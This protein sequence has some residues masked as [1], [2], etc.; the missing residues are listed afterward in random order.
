MKE[1]AK[2]TRTKRKAKASDECELKNTVSTPTMERFAK[3]RNVRN[4]TNFIFGSVREMKMY[5]LIP[6]WVGSRDDDQWY[7]DDHGHLSTRPDSSEWHPLTKRRNGEGHWR[8]ALNLGFFRAGVRIVE[9][10]LPRDGECRGTLRAEPRWTK[11]MPVPLY[12]QDLMVEAGIE[13]PS[14][15]AVEYIRAHSH[16]YIWTQE[17]LEKV[18]SALKTSDAV[19][20]QKEMM[21]DLKIDMLADKDISS[22]LNIA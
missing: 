13:H 8:L 3:T 12:A 10:R 7:L 1:K 9:W 15:A 21:F 4:F 6:D 20:P 22:P 16:A 14:D 18:V 19:A 11:N 2:D 5:A 17:R